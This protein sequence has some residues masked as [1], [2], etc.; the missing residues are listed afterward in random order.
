[1]PWLNGLQQNPAR[2]RAKNARTA[3]HDTAW[4]AVDWGSSRLRVWGVGADGAV[5]G[6]KQN[7]HGAA[8]L[9]PDMFERR[10]LETAVELLLPGRVTPVLV[11]GMAGARD[12]WRETPYLPVP[13]SPLMVGRQAQ[14]APTRNQRL[15]VR[16]LAGVSQ[17][18]PADVMRGEETQLAGLLSMRPGF[19]GVVCLPGTHTKWARMERGVLVAF[20]T[21]MSGELFH[22]LGATSSLRRAVQARAWDEGAFIAAADEVIAA[23]Q[24]A[25]ARLFSIRAERLLRG[26]AATTGRARL[27]GICIGL[28]LAAAQDYWSGGRVTLIG[29]QDLCRQY[30]L[31]LQSRRVETATIA[32]KAAALAGLIALYPTTCETQSAT[33]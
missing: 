26:L 28:E 14:T 11:C 33:C 18:A 5:T 6:E 29:E 7:N 20:T 1:M 12:R 19:S 15:T 4:L 13:C 31:A 16:I 27:S 30:T 22:W 32:A 17:Q 8:D 21:Y 25:A 2:G 24:K 23:P 10:L 3:A 9:N